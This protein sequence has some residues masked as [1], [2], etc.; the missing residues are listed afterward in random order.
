V[1]RLK[2]YTAQVRGTTYTFNGLAE[3]MAKATPLRSGD[4]LAGCAAST[5]AERAAAQWALADVALDVFLEEM[6][7]PYEDDE[8]TRLI[9]D[10]HDRVAFQRISHLTVGGLRDWLLA[11]VAGPGAANAIAAISRAITPEM[12]AAVSKIMRNQDLIAIARAITVTSGFRTTVGLPGTLATRLQPNHPTDDPR[13]IAAATLDGLL[14]GCGDAVIGINPATD[15]PQA[16]ADLLMLLDEIRSRYAIPAQ[17]CVLSH[18]TTTIE[19][20]ERGAPV[21]L[22]F[23]SV[24]GSEGANKAFGVDIALLREGLAA[25]RSLNRGTVGNNVMYLETGQGSALSSGAHLGIGGQPVDQQTL[26]TRAYAV[27]RDLEPLLVNTVVGFIGPEYLYDGKQIIRAGLED[28]FCGKL[29]GLPMG[30]DVCYTN[31][32]EADQDD[33]DTLLTLLGAAGVAFV[34]A[35]PGADDVMLGY[36]SLSFHDVLYARQ[37]LGL[38]PAPEFDAWLRG[39]GISDAEGRVLPIDVDQSPLRALT[40]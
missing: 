10:S 34:I 8:V 20:I 36:Q 18:V 38:R 35:V 24:A 17:S 26:E 30:V 12:A 15:S 39:L 16:T 29:L 21:D 11:V 31:H 13:G 28:H 40:G 27:A 6:V 4:E 25:G 1:T 32:A 37:V 33:M 5:D 2:R 22:V 23:Q 14:L 19:L 7:V 3:V 9:I